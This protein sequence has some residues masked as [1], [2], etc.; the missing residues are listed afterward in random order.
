MGGYLATIFE[1]RGELVVSEVVLSIDFEEIEGPLRLGVLSLWLGCLN[2][3]AERWRR[4]HEVAVA[5]ALRTA[6]ER[7]GLPDAGG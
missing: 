2:L 5:V 1:V 4:R 7:L 6:R 3:D